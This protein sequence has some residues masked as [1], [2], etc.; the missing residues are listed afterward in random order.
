VK[1]KLTLI[2]PS[3]IVALLV[4]TRIVHLR[5]GRT[6]VSDGAIA[7]DVEVAKPNVSPSHV[8]AE[9]SA[10]VIEDYLT[11]ELPDDF[12][13]SQLIRRGDVYA[14]PSGVTLNPIYIDYLRRALPESRLRMK[15]SSEPVVIEL[16]GKAVGLLMP[17]RSA[18]P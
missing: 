5:D 17:M 1:T 8:L 6:F 14:A 12:A 15:G 16:N 4:W 13:L 18:N 9:A 11:A 7:L 3:A 10:K 2:A